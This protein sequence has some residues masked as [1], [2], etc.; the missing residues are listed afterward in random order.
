MPRGFLPFMILLLAIDMALPAWGKRN[1]AP[2]TQ[3]TA[4]ETPREA[5]S[6][7]NQYSPP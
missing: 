1:P 4:R 6:K 5:K 2:A 3:P 7:L